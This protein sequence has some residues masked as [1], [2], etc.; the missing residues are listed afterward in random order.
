MQSKDWAGQ[1]RF[2]NIYK[3]TITIAPRV[4]VVFLFL[5]KSVC[6]VCVPPIAVPKYIYMSSCRLITYSDWDRGAPDGSGLG[7][8]PL[9]YC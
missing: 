3:Y 7:L 4:L 2:K 1:W 6:L 9:P 5:A 8:R